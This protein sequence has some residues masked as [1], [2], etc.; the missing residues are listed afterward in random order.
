VE[1]DRVLATVLFIDVVGS[2]ERLAALGDHQWRRVLDQHD[3]MVRGELRR[4]RGKE[5]KTTGDG[6][7][8]TFDGPARAIRCA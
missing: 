2:T 5:V 3:A 1:I 7:V 4:F 6:F 8:A